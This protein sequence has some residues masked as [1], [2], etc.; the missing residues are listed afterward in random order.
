MKMKLHWSVRILCLWFAGSPFAHATL[1]QWQNEVLNIGAPPAATSFTT[2]SGTNPLLLDV[3]PLTG[4]RSFEFIVNADR[5]GVSGAFLGNRQANGAQGLKFEQFNASGVL[6]ITNFGVVDLYSDDPSPVNVDTHVAFVSDGVS[7]TELYVN[8]TNVHSFSGFPLQIFGMQ[9]LAGIA[10]ST[11][12]FTDLLAGNI[13]GF[14]SYDSEL[15]AS[16]VRAHANAFAIPEPS[17][18]APLAVF[19]GMSI[20]GTRRHA[21]A[22]S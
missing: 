17:V 10:E 7:G 2:V 22:R 20:V 4:D 9:G 12:A 21:R 3:G 16:E 6:G 11:G 1:V 8:G 14:A 18:F 5:G 19:V 13:L 15:S